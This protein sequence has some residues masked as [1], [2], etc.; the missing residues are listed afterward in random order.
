MNNNQS[1]LSE[2]ITDTPHDRNISGFLQENDLAFQQHIA[3]EAEKERVAGQ[4]RGKS[5]KVSQLQLERSILLENLPEFQKAQFARSIL[6]S[7][8]NSPAGIA[9]IVF[10]AQQLTGA[11]LLGEVSAEI[12]KIQEQELRGAESE[13]TDF[14]KEHA[15]ML[16]EL[17]LI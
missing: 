2:K 7:A 3:R 9:S 14:K 10:V 12:L 6:V 4:F 8:R 11:R 13:L 16:R 5:E 1:V 15:K 17:K